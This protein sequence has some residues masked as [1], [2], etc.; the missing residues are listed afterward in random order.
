M[1]IF[2]FRKLPCGVRVAGTGAYL[3]ER[4]VSNADISALGCPMT[5]EEI[6]KGLGI[7]E[8]RWSSSEQASSDLAAA[9]CAQALRRAG[10]A[11]VDV[12]RLIVATVTPD[13]P[14]PSTACF[15]HAQ[16]QMGAAPAYDITATCTGFIYAMDQG[17]RAV[18]TG[19]GNTLVCAADTRSKFIDAKDRASAPVF[20]DGAGAALLE[21]CTQGHGVLG[22]GVFA[23]SRGR[24]SVYIP[25]GGSRAP[26]TEERVRAGEHH[27]RMTSGPEAYLAVIEGMV[28]TAEQLLEGLSLTID[29]IALVVP[30]QANGRVLARLARLLRCGEDKIFR[31]VSHY[32]NMSGAATAVAFHEALASGHLRAG[33]KLLLVAG[34]AGYTAGGLVVQVDEALLERAKT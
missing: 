22:L 3:P 9:A 29:D 4:R 32:G 11:A 16:L 34:G 21:P 6:E 26:M 13:H 31:N 23:D 33:D 27:V 24:H 28:L 18:L 25:A 20:G 2:D 12:A 14:S 17:V 1:K 15:V 30:H 10:V 5:P 8:R 19:E 7:V